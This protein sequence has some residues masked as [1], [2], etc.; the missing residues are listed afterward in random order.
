[1]DFPRSLTAAAQ[2]RRL[3]ASSSNHCL[4]LRTG[5]CIS[6]YQLLHK[7]EMW[8]AQV[9]DVGEI[10]KC[11]TFFAFAQ[12]SDCVGIEW[13]GEGQA[14]VGNLTEVSDLHDSRERDA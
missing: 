11:A 1:M 7:D 10:V 12:I 5:L 8:C 9:T 13:E 6:L 4:L 14:N 2:S 3:A